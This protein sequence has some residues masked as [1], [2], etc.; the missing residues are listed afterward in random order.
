L[1]PSRRRRSRKMTS[2][3]AISSRLES[4]PQAGNSLLPIND[5]P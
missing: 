2:G 5:Y 3:Q 1:P 4:Y